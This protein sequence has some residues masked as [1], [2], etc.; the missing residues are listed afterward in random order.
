MKLISE[1]L[2]MDGTK[3]AKIY[4]TN[5]TQPEYTVIVKADTGTHYRVTF[6]SIDKA[7]DYAE[8]WTL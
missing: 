8:D 5:T 4:L 3:T 7:E 1:H 6:D 2:S